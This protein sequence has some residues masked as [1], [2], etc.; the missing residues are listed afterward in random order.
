MPWIVPKCQPS[1]PLCLCG[2]RTDAK[3]PE[4]YL[5]SGT[6]ERRRFDPSQPWNP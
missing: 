5:T 4:I 3:A 1:V 6:T 2:E